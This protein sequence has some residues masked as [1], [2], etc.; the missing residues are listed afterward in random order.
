MLM[1]DTVYIK[2]ITN[3]KNIS[4]INVHILHNCIDKEQKTP[5]QTTSCRN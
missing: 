5:R 3:N 4:N 2:K 1:T